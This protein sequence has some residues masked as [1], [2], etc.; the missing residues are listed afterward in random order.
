VSRR[1]YL[2]T[3]DIA[4]DKRRE[5]VFRLLEDNGD[6]VQYS[7]FYCEL[8]EQERILV[9]G[10]LNELIHHDDDQVLILDL[11]QGAAPLES[12]L[13]TLGRNYV[14]PCRVQVV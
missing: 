3:Y 5:Q 14:P 2:V 9:E 13:R 8:N 6:H 1:H 7:V 11:G 4:D 12:A 10:G